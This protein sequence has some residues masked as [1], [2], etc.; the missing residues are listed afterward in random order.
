MTTSNVFN[1]DCVEYMR[2]LPDNAFD[3]AIADPPY[4][5]ANDPTFSPR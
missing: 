2:S 3:L 1:C 5:G 4:G